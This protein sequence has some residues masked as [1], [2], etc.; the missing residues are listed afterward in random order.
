MAKAIITANTRADIRFFGSF[1]LF[2]GL[3]ICPCRE[4][5]MPTGWRQFLAL[6]VAYYPPFDSRFP[7]GRTQPFGL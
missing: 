6:L 5:D 3:P 7:L 4:R 2:R 1:C